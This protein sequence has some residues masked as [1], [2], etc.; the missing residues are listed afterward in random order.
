MSVGIYFLYI[1]FLI[2]TEHN[3]PVFEKNSKK[4]ALNLNALKCL[5]NS[6]IDPVNWKEQKIRTSVSK[7]LNTCIHTTQPHVPF[8]AYFVLSANIL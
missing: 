1:L 7:A 6:C 2:K 5:M 3:I 4:G 8:Q